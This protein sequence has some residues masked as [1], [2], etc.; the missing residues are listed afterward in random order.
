MLITWQTVHCRTCSSISDTMFCYVVTHVILAHYV[1]S[2]KSWISREQIEIHRLP[3][4][5][6]LIP[7]YEFLASGAPAP[8]CFDAFVVAF[9]A[10]N[11]NQDPNP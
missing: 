7:E 2:N 6:S 9:M 10:E 5:P 1:R 11:N 4:V 8:R 3:W